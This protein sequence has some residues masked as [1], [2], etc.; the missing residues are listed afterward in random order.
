MTH[1][2]L[3]S[4]D[5]LVAVYPHRETPAEIKQ[6]IG[7]AIDDTHAPAGPQQW[8]GGPRRPDPSSGL[9]VRG[10]HLH[11]PHE[12]RFQLRRCG[13]P[14]GNASSRHGRRCDHKRYG[15]RAREFDAWLRHSYGPPDIEVKGKPVS[16]DRFRGKKGLISFDILFGVDAITH[17]RATGHV[18]LWDGIT[19][20]DEI[21]GISRPNRDFLNVANGVALWL[22]DGKTMLHP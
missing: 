18:D 16:R 17:Q 12:P 9:V 14:E 11:D 22:A 20:Y 2:Q 8:L 21:A 7:G 19:F 5:A 15:F 6:K 4:F 10:R 13:H 3:P 1:R